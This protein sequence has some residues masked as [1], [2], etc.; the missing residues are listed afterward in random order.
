M[1]YRDSTRQI[2]MIS[3]RLNGQRLVAMD[4]TLHGFDRCLINIVDAARN[5]LQEREVA[6]EDPRNC[7]GRNDFVV[8]AD[9]PE[10]VFDRPKG[11][12]SVEECPK[13]RAILVISK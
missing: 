3:Y 6:G 2:A 11:E 12:L 7:L 5:W 8:D 10:V 13:I 1:E 9:R 4:G